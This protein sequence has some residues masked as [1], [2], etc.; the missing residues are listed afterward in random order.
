MLKNKYAI[1][2]KDNK[3]N[4][5]SKCVDAE[6]AKAG[7]DGSD[8]IT[9]GCCQTETPGGKGNFKQCLSIVPTI[10]PDSCDGAAFQCQ[11]ASG[12]GKGSS[13]VSYCANIAIGKGAT[14]TF[15]ISDECGDP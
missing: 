9:C 6:N 7:I 4:F 5:E 2:V 10:E 12:K 8:T 15:G 11:T 3:G 13:G 1:C 14:P